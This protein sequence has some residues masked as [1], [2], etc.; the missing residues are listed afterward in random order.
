MNLPSVDARIPSTAWRAEYLEA[1]RK[2][3]VKTY[4][5]RMAGVSMQEVTVHA[6]RDPAFAEQ[7]AEALRE[8][9]D[10]ALVELRR[11]AMVGHKRRRRL[12]DGTVVEETT[13]SDF[14]LLALN[15]A[16]NPDLFT[17]RK[18]VHHTG[19][20]SLA[21][22]IAKVEAMEPDPDVLGGTVTT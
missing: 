8:A 13:P 11:R 14:L 12:P 4:A 19:A 2:V 1:L 16:L 20:L 22:A 10:L 21:A 15:K 17:E 6:T 9:A 7:A 5:A 18:A 3:G